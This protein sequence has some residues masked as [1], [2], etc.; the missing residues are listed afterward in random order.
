MNKGK[1]AIK[2]SALVVITVIIVLL[3]LTGLPLSKIFGVYDIKPFGEMISYGID[4]T[5]GTQYVIKIADGE[6]AAEKALS[7]IKGIMQKRLRAYGVTNYRLYEKDDRIYL[8]VDTIADA[9]DFE[10]YM[11]RVGYITYKNSSGDILLDGSHISEAAATSYYYSDTKTYPAVTV[12]FDEEGTEMLSTI[13]STYFYQTLTIALDEETIS[14]PTITTN[15]TNGQMYLSIL[16]SELAA[17]RLAGLVNSGTFPC[18]VTI[19][20]ADV[21]TS[22]ID[23]GLL[24]AL[25]YTALAALILMLLTELLMFKQGGLAC[26]I[27]LTVYVGSMITFA[28]FSGIGFDLMEAVAM[29]V[30]TIIVFLASLKYLFD[31][32]KEQKLGKTL[33]SSMDATAKKQKKLNL[34]ISGAEFVLGGVM[35]CMQIDSLMK[36]AYTIMFSAVATLLILWIQQKNTRITAILFDSTK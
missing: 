7:Q 18:A 4:F 30:L 12:T 22:V 20:S 36:I 28:A 9:E 27:C 14:S 17:Q 5:G 6:Q 1:S 24:S 26:A 32:K 13:T 15:I 19:E 16:Q 21:V 35:F 33:L 11:T 23:P 3:V 25:K 31:V 29:S 34:I 8:S 2:F 10:K